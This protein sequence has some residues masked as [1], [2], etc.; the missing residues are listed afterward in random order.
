MPVTFTPLPTYPPDEANKII[1]DLFKNP[2]CKL[3]CWSN[4]TP[5]KTDWN[6]P[7]QFLGRFARNEPFV[8]SQNFDPEFLPGYIILPVELGIV[9]KGN[10]EY[11]K[12]G[13]DIEVILNKETLLV[14]F[15]DLQTGTFCS[16]TPDN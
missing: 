5:G 11:F 2:T 10:Y 9:K 15:I 13:A 8:D 3:P 7:W 16:R 4:I 6:N 12:T 14:D 1:L